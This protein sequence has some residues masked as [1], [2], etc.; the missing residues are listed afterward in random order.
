L[1]DKQCVDV[2]AGK[3]TVLPDRRLAKFTIDER[4]W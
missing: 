2:C 4:K 3:G 1:L